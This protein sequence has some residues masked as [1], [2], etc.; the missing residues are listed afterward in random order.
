[1][2]YGRDTIQKGRRARELLG[3]GGLEKGLTCPGDATQNHD[4]GGSSRRALKGL[5]G[6]GSL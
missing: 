1:M 5:S 6:L 2:A 4:S 3:R